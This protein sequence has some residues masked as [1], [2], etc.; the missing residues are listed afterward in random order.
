MC[1]PVNI[2]SPGNW[3]EIEKSTDPD[4]TFPEASRTM[5]ARIVAMPRAAMSIGGFSFDGNIMARK[6]TVSAVC[7]KADAAQI[8]SKV[9]RRF[10]AVSFDRSTPHIVSRRK[11][12]GNF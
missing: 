4:T 5:W 3:Y 8:V 11:H 9:N 1:R 12:L 6:Y 2:A 10:M 7:A